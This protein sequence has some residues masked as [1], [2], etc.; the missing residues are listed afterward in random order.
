MLAAQTYYG[1]FAP[2]SGKTLIFE[3]SGKTLVCPHARAQLTNAA[4]FAPT[5]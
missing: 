2:V 5:R 4:A 3:K 1:R